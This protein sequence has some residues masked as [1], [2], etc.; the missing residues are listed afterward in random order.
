ME[1][2]TK[3]NKLQSLYECSMEVVF[4]LLEIDNMS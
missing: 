4:E 1:R 3:F 2:F